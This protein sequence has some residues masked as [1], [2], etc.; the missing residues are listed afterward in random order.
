MVLYTVNPSTLPGAFQ[1]CS[2]KNLLFPCPPAGLLG[3]G[4]CC[5]D[6]QVCVPGGAAPPPCQVQGSVGAVYPVRPLFPGGPNPPRHRVTPGG[7]ATLVVASSPALESA[8]AVTTTGPSPQGP[9]C[10]G[11]GD[12]DL[13]S[14]GVHVGRG[15]LSVLC[16]PGLRLS[17][18]GVQDP[19]QCPP[20]P[21]DLGPVP[22]ESRSWGP[23]PPHPEPPPELL[24]RPHGAQ[25]P[26]LYC[27]LRCV[28]PSPPVHLLCW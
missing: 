25:A 7:T 17:P 18:G 9:G 14:L 16:L 22:L 26:A 27:R 4:A 2:A 6:S 8:P 28:G 19:G 20:A 11:A 5:A 24:P 23:E 12:A 10:S 1:H 13:H 15:V 3:G 21:W